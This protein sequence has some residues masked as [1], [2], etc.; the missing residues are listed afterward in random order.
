MPAFINV[1]EI[2]VFLVNHDWP[3]NQP[4]E[5]MRDVILTIKILECSVIHNMKINIF[6]KNTTFIAYIFEH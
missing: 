5:D 4:S 2:S 1:H 3:T 6:N